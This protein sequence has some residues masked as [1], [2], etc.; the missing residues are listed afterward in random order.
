MIKILPLHESDVLKN[1]NE[2]Q[3]TNAS[4]AYCMYDSEEIGAY[5]LYDIKEMQ[6]EI[7]AINSNDIH[8]TDGLIRATIS[9]LLDLK[10]DKAVFSKNINMED[11]YKLELV[12]DGTFAIPSINNLLYNCKNCQKKNNI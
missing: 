3:R 10:I 2:T 4:L 8:I 6:G 9:S 12:T 1:L 7:V 11:I 5:L